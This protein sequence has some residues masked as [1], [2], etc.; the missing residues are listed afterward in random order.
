MSEER[1]YSDVTEEN[2]T[3]VPVDSV[4][5]QEPVNAKQGLAKAAL[6]F[7]ILA[8]I[9][10]LFLLNYIFGILALVFGIIYLAK[11]ADV[12]PKG[13][14]IT[15]IVLASLSLIISTTIWVGA[16]VYFTNT[17]ITDIIEDFGTLTGQELDGREMINNAITNAV[18]G[19][20]MIGDKPLNLDTIEAFV[21]GEVSVDRVLDF[22]GDVKPE[23]ITGFVSELQNMDMEKVNGIMSEF[24][25]EVTYEKLE[26]KLGEEFSLEDI[27]DYIKEYQAPTQE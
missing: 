23:E 18:G 4:A 6:V 22:V 20:V 17:E 19:E 10:T 5:P 2:V 25:G 21:G 24:E 15:G 14:A 12:K 16:Y 13:K 9:T 27:M 7:G 8:F 1:I 3:E 26:E 11:K